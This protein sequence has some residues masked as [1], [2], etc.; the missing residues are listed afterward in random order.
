MITRLAPIIAIVRATGIVV[1]DLEHRRFRGLNTAMIS[2]LLRGTRVYAPR[3][4]KSQG[5]R[6]R[7]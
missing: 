4:P 1:Y 6:A 3:S 2:T 5:R 7:A